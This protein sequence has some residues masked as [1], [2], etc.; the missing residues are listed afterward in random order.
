MHVKGTIDAAL[1]KAVAGSDSGGMSNVAD[2]SEQ[3][4]QLLFLKLEV[5]RW[6]LIKWRGVYDYIFWTDAGTYSNGD[7]GSTYKF[8]GL[9]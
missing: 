3:Y 8:A 2:Q 5:L 9:P 1:A 6:Y 4:S 7:N